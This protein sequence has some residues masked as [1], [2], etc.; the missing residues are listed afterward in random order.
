MLPIKD[1]S[2]STY[3]LLSTLAVLFWKS[4][5]LGKSQVLKSPPGPWKL[6]ILGNLLQ[7]AGHPLPHYPLRDLAKKYGPV[8]HLKLGQSTAVIISSHNAALEVLKTNEITFAQRPLV[9]QVETINFGRGSIAFAPYGDFWREMR[10]ICVSELLS[11]KHVQAFRFIREEEVKN[12]VESI[13]TSSSK[14]AAINFSEESLLL[15]NGII[16]RAAFGNKCKYQK[17][18]LAVLDEALKLGGGFDIPDLFPSLRFL[19]FF[20]GTITAM[21]KMRDK[22]GV[23]LD[24]IIDE[25]KRKRSLKNDRPE[26]ADHDGKEEEDLVDILL[27]LQDSNNELDFKLTTGQIKDVVMEI[28]VA[29]SE[30]SA[31]TLEWAMSELL[32]NPRVMK[33]AQA[34]VRQ[35]VLLTSEDNTLDNV[36]HKMDYLKSIVKETLRLHPPTPLLARESRE[37]CEIDGYELPA[38]TKAIIN[39]W[40]LARDPEQW[41]DDADSFKPERF[42]DDSMTAKIDFRGSN[43]ELIPFG[44]GRRIC[45]GMSFANAVIELTLF[46]LLYHFDWELANGIKPDELDMTESW[47]ATCR[48]RDDLYII[49]TPHFETKS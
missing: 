2:L 44:S 10:K 38:K 13:S 49:A 29:G 24:S 15:T 36:Q 17:E 12:F 39:V 31:A 4:S 35:S 45:P 25:H 3:L 42:L 34:E 5:R 28:F 47:G 22:I 7:L 14:S 33:A 26:G 9:L 32:K 16:S 8:M 48:K 43:F 20:T 1:F 11:V 19:C 27:K 21:R 18:F 40:A 23:A 41:G 6:P 46:Q 30:T 37:R